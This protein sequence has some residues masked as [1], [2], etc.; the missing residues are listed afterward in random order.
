MT[1]TTRDDK[2]RLL[3]QCILRARGVVH[4]QVL[5]QFL[6]ALDGEEGA[7]ELGTYVTEMN[8][9]LRG[10]GY[11]VKRVTHGLGR[12][13]AGEQ[14][15]AEGGRFYVYVNVGASREAELATTF[16]PAELEFAKWAI[17]QLGTLGPLE[18]AGEHGHAAAE[19]EVD[20]VLAAWRGEPCRLRQRATYAERAKTL[21]TY[22]DLT[23]SEIERLLMRLCELKWF[24]RTAEGSYGFDLRLLV[25]LEEYLLE[26][27]TLMPCSTCE[28]VV[29]QGVLCTGCVS[30]HRDEGSGWAAWHVDCFDYQV[31]HVAPQC[32][33]CKADIL[34]VGAYLV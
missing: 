11:Q 34:T 24:Y 33:T 27:H 13:Y 1:E 14:A 9:R 5:A 29:A 19:R 31:N 26:N 2:R 7:D 15:G 32:P 16:R 6:A 8:V 25:E 3:L 17:A 18:E 20:R 10:L 12:R 28:H 23:S 4:E 22:P 30:K 21:L